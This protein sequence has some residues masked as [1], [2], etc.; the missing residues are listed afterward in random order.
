V[1]REE[2]ELVW[3]AGHDAVVA[4]IEAQA[5]RVDELVLRVQELERQAGRSSRNSSLPPSRDSS[6]PRK[7]RPK[8]QSGRKQ[9]GQSGHPGRHRLD[10]R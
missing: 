7:E 9:G 3:A 5:S 4:L 8:K 2:I 1:R 6:Q 10:G